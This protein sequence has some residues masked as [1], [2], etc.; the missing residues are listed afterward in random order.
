M[1]LYSDMYNNTR[2]LCTDTIA[3]AR[4][5]VCSL[6]RPK[7]FR[8]LVL[9]WDLFFSKFYQCRNPWVPWPATQYPFIKQKALSLHSRIINTYF[10]LTEPR[11]REATYKVTVDSGYPGGRGRPGYRHTSAHLYRIHEIGREWGIAWRIRVGDS[12]VCLWWYIQ[13]ERNHKVHGRRRW[14]VIIDRAERE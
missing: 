13:V 2:L 5:S 9:G 12:I 3:P 8:W 11:R 6:W 1:T 7:L 10:T 14:C 4:T